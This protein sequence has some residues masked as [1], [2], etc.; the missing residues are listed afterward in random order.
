MIS[1]IITTYGG[2]SRLQCAIDSVRSQTYTDIE[3]I[4]VDDNNPDTE[5]RR[6]TEKVMREYESDDR[7]KYLKHERNKNGATARN[8]GIK[9]SAG[10]YISFLDDDDYYLHGRF[11]N[12]LN[13]FSDNTDLVG[14]Y[15]GVDMLDENGYNVMKIRPER[16]L[17]A[18][19]LL[20]NEMALGTG[21]NIFVKS[22]VVKEVNGFDESFVR[23]QDIEFMIR[24]CECGKV[25][26]ISDSLV[27]KSVNGVAN[28]PKYEKM[29]LVIDLFAHKFE[30]QAEALGEKKK[31]FYCI[32]YRTLFGI[33]LYEHNPA[34][35]KEAM[36][37]I[38][39]YGKITAKERMLAFVYINNLRDIGIVKSLINAKK[40]IASNK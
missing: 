31:D 22:N 17:S 3:I 19:E 14:V 30:K 23:R 16:E 38:Q 36:G 10:E 18:R 7:V 34:E 27:I 4:V 11:E 28:H 15:T 1:T 26:Y 12:I 33:A 8:T 9:E 2:G 25:G 32:Q 21:S 29:R 20:L 13:V 6:Q 24:V 35:I 5:A 37:L 39:K 40:A